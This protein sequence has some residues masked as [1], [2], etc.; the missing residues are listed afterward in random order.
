M[1]Y[2]RI[3]FITLLFLSVAVSA[4]GKQPDPD[5]EIL[6]VKEYTTVMKNGKVLVD[7]VHGKEVK[8]WYGAVGSEKSN[9]VAYIHVFEDGTSVVTANVNILIADEGTHYQVYLKSADGKKQIDVGELQSII[10]DARHSVRF[11]TTEDLSSMLNMEVRHEKGLL[12][13]SEVVGTGTLKEPAP[14]VHQ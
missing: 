6:E 9:G 1:K 12:A 10:G 5:G 8:F 7:P 11:E 3:A 2:P 4:C 13:G 14:A